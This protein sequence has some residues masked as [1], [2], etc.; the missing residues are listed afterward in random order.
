MTRIPLIPGPKW[1]PIV[2]RA[3]MDFCRGRLTS[4][5][6]TPE[7]CHSSQACLVNL[8]CVSTLLLCRFQFSSGN[9]IRKLAVIGNCR[10]QMKCGHVNMAVTQPA[11]LWRHRSRPRRHDH[12]RHP[13]RYGLV[14]ADRLI[15]LQWP[16]HR[17]PRLRHRPGGL[18][19][20][21][22][23]RLLDSHLGAFYLRNDQT[24]HSLRAATEDG[25]SIYAAFVR[26]E[27]RKL[28]RMSEGRCRRRRLRQ[29]FWTT[30]LIPDIGNPL[31]RSQ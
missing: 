7:F 24:C 16:G 13:R 17:L 12:R 9:S 1:L 6:G 31:N 18:Y 5:R 30:P 21:G 8:R 3:E 26:A 10:N 2:Q 23:Q 11:L 15:N 25:V 19:E 28:R 14:P 20:S 27:R 4:S 22:V 29:D